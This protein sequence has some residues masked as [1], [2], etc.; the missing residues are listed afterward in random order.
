[1]LQPACLQTFAKR[2]KEGRKEGEGKKG[3][4][5]HQACGCE[6]NKVLKKKG[7]DLF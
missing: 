2:R 5:V 4:W 3:S 1:M 7:G 6:W